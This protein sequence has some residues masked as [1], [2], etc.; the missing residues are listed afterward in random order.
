[1]NNIYLLIVVY[2]LLTLIFLFI[3]KKIA[4]GITR[5]DDDQAIREAGNMAVALRRF[6]LFLGLGVAMTGV[7]SGGLSRLD[8]L[9]Y[10]LDG[11]I[12]VLLFFLA[13]YVNEYLLVPGVSN[14]DLIKAGNVPTGLVEAGSFLATGILLNGAFAGEEG[15]L[16]TAVVFFLLGQ[17]F[18]VIAVK[19]HQKV[20][21]FNVTACLKEQN[22]SAGVTVAGLLVS[23]SFILRTTI[24]GNF[25]GWADSLGYFTAS[26]LTGIVGLFV[27]ERLAGFVFLTRIRI[28]DEIARANTAAAILI[29]GITL[30]L[31]LIISRLL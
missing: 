26:A 15:S 1:M 31:A 23:Y 20:Y 18:M 6:G 9:T 16:L 29:Q 11:G 17:S 12:A 21:R 27:F 5:F 3:A 30:T 8:M 7:M 14:N 24:A 4:D 28:T 13:H 2:V 19:I 10:I 25:A 22:L